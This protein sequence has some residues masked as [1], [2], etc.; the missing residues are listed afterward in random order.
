L[1]ILYLN[2]VIVYVQVLTVPYR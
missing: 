1:H 2:I